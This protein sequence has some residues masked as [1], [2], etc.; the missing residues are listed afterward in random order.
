MKLEGKRDL[1]AR[2]L[3]VGKNRIMF[4]EERLSD[5]K[6][7]ITKQDMRDLAR[8][9]AILIREVQGRKKVIRRTTRR[10]AGSI[11]KKVN[12]RKKDYMAITR[13]LRAYVKL[14]RDKKG[15]TKEDYYTLRKEIRAKQ[16]KSKGNMRERIKQLGDK[17]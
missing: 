13:K 12:T 7:A 6:E 17:K 2:A 10:K 15:I 16:F 9:K 11:K 5:V 4:N 3:K 14:L 8:S 1:A